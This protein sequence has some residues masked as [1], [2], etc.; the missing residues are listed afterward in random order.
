MNRTGTVRPLTWALLA[1]S[2]LLS[3]CDLLR[4]DRLEEIRARGE[5]RVATL[6]SPTTYFIG[7]EGP[8]G[9]EYELAERFATSLGVDLANS[10]RTAASA[11]RE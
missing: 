10:T 8:E 11:A 4:S 9:L 5:L 2:L 1:L 6:N 3:G 7:A